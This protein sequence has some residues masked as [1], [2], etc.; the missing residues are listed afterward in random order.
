MSHLE[1]KKD[2]E[3]L[4]K[5][6]PWN[7]KLKLIYLRVWSWLTRETC[8]GGSHN[9]LPFWLTRTLVI[10][11]QKVSEHMCC[12]C[13]GNSFSF[14]DFY[15]TFNKTWMTGCVC[16]TM[17]PA[18]LSLFFRTANITDDRLLRPIF[19]VTFADTGI[20]DDQNEKYQKTV[21]ILIVSNLSECHWH[22]WDLCW[23]YAKHW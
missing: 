21:R 23:S 20:L 1:L 11:S 2:G 8:R 3:V 15:E 22:L 14:V 13:D 18:V 19:V 12:A 16:E 6:M 7:D 4:M 5:R 10:N 17:R 9:P